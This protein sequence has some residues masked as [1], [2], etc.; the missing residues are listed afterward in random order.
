M[1]TTREVE[2]AYFALLRRAGLS[3]RYERMAS[4]TDSMN[5]LAR[6]GIA[7]QYP[8]WSRREVMIEWARRQYGEDIVSKLLK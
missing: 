1:D 8:D 2:E 3:R 5:D 4:W 7:R 6:A